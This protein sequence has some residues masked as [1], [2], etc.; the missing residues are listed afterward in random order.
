MYG[1][2]NAQELLA[3]AQVFLIDARPYSDFVVGHIQ[4]AVSTR[5]SSILIRRLGKNTI[6]V[7]DLLVEEQKVRVSLD[8][9]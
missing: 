6:G 8:S 1:S 2:P 3:S 7:A 9:F 5:L 4:G